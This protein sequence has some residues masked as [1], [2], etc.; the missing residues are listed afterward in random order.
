M[1][2]SYVSSMSMIQYRYW[3]VTQ[4]EGQRVLLCHLLSNPL[5]HP[6]RCVLVENYIY[7]FKFETKSSFQYS[8]ETKD[9]RANSHYWLRQFN[10]VEFKPY[11]KR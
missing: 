11:Y 4:N 7:S 6:G 5:R 2:N 9:C 1:V 3:Q 8:E 10:E